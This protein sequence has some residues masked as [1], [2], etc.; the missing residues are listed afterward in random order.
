MQT[1]RTRA[2]DPNCSTEEPSRTQVATLIRQ[3]IAQILRDNGG[4]REM[5]DIDDEDDLRR[6]L[7]FDSL[8]LAVLVIRLEQQLGIDPFRQRTHR[9]HTVGQLIALYQQAVQADGR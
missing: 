9:V 2:E 7:G 3:T 8:D 4:G 1:N 6:T 5:A